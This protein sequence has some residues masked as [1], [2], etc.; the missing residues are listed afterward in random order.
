MGSLNLKHVAQVSRVTDL[1]DET[2]IDDRQWV[3]EVMCRPDISVN[4]KGKLYDILNKKLYHKRTLRPIFDENVYRA[5]RPVFPF[6]VTDELSKVVVNLEE[7]NKLNATIAVLRLTEPFGPFN[8]KHEYTNA[9]RLLLWAQD[10]QVGQA[11]E[12][13]KDAVEVLNECIRTLEFFSLPLS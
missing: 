8:T 13:V 1:A 9:V 5:H 10:E 3:R 11:Q 12:V 7:E 2:I 6:T 4:D